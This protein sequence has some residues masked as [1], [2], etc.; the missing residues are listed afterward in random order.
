MFQVMGESHTGKTLILRKGFANEDDALDHPVRL[1]HWKRIWIEKSLPEEQPD[2]SAPPFPWSVRWA[3]TL[4]YM[5][6]ANGKVFATLL[7]TQARREHVVTILC[8]LSDSRCTK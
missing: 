1:A 4:T 5:L 3:G 2:N 6:D 7:G 8:D